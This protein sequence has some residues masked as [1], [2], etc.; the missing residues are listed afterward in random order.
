[1][2]E[3]DGGIKAM[4]HG[5]GIGEVQVSLLLVLIQNFFQTLIHF[6]L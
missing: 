1:M 2:G 6:Y 5:R 3:E 4:K